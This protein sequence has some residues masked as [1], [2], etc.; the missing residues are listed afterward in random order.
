MGRNYVGTVGKSKSARAKKNEG[1]DLFFRI[2]KNILTQKSLA[3][4]QEH[5]LDPTFEDVYANVSAEKAISKCTDSKVVVRLAEI[6]TDY[7]R[8]TDKKRHYWFLMRSLPRT[9]SYIDWRA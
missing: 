5:L 3:L 8:I 4:F 9:N 2:L 7:S 1:N 6:Q